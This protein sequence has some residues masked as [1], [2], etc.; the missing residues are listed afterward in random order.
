MTCFD[1][2]N[3]ANEIFHLSIINKYLSFYVVFKDKTN[4]QTNFNQNKKL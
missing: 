4:P 3:N 1:D 2:Q